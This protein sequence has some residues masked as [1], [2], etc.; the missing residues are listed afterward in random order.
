MERTPCGRCRPRW[1]KRASA[2]CS[3][4][5]SGTRILVI[6]HPSRSARRSA[7]NTPAVNDSGTSSFVG[8]EIIKSDRPELTAA[9]VIV[10]GGRAMGSS[11]QFNDVPTPLA[12]KLGAA[13]GASRAAVDAGYAPNDCPCR[14]DPARSWRHSC[15]S[16]AAARAQ[17]STWPA[18]GLE[19]D[20]FGGARTDQGFVVHEE[21]IM[22]DGPSAVVTAAHQVRT[23]R[24]S[25][26]RVRDHR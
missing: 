3:R 16:P 23:K 4:W 21:N 18:Y 1:A 19:A 20:L 2:P 9:K 25:N 26:E 12:D 24:G 15:T 14:P 10:S 22:L 17:F 6:A 11:S 7:S 8:R 5:P 13:L